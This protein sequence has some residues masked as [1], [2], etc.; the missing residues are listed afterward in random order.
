METITISELIVIIGLLI[1][2]GLLSI[3]ISTLFYAEKRASRNANSLS[4]ISHHQ[5]SK[6]L[7]KTENLI[8]KALDSNKLP[9]RLSKKQL[10]RIKEYLYY[11]VY[12]LMLTDNYIE[13]IAIMAVHSN[14]SEKGFLLE[15]Y[16]SFPNP[17]IREAIL[18]SDK[19]SI[20]DRTMLVLSRKN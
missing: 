9:N 1:T 20:E 12:D 2:L 7:W 4:I 3:L 16:E 13:K 6:N 5:T 18:K 10:Q 14:R 11:S 19:L 15:I 17:T 8:K